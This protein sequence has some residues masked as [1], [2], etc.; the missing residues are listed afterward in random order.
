MQA[1][2]PSRREALEMI[3]SRWSPETETE[4]VAVEDAA[5][6]V[7]AR[8]VAAVHSL[9]VVRASAMDG[10]GVDSALFADGMPDTSA[11]ELGRDYIRADTGD[12]FDEHFDAVIAIEDV[13]FTDGGIAL[14]DGLSV[15]PGTNVRPSGSTV[16]LGEPLVGAGTLLRPVHLGALHLGGVTE[17]DVL[18][19]PVVA[20]I[21]TGSEL[22]PPG[23]APKRG[24][25]TDSNSVMVCAMLAELGAE[26]LV[27]PIVRDNPKELRAALT[28]AAQVADIVL[29][30]GGSSKGGEDFNASLISEMGEMI[31]HWVSSAPGR[32]MCAAM[33]DDKP[34]INLPGPPLAAYFVVDWCVSA[35]I[36]RY[37]GIDAPARATVKA[38]L[39]ADVDATP[40]MEVLR[41][42]ELEH[43]PAGLVARPLKSRGGSAVKTLTAPARLV[44]DGGDAPLAAGEVID[45]LVI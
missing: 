41:K 1:K 29:V 45:A 21:P 28:T 18:R 13:T 8:D 20:F 35:L 24:E 40:G 42:L 30:N 43:T 38:A 2:P 31:F 16:R 6:R 39:A 7:A 4:T 37:Y 17:V 19:R 26:P 25:T 36:A 5:G 27:L 14:A 11:W 15:S 33:F 3:F 9:P 34:L 44:T 22:I 12:D 23:T 32:P 10:I